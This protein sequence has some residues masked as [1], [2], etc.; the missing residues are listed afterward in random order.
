VR[1]ADGTV[2][3]Q[4]PASVINPTSLGAL[5]RQFGFPLEMPLGDFEIVM[6]VRDELAGKELE[7]REPFAVVTPPPE[8][9]AGSAAAQTAP[10]P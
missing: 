4:H 10:S 2:L 7:V 8:P 6:T 9:P 1:G 5:S 3:M